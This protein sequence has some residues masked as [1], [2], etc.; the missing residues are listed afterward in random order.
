MKK[1][2]AYKRIMILSITA[3]IIFILQFTLS[4]VQT[5]ILLYLTTFSMLLFLP[6]WLKDKEMRKSSKFIL[7]FI[8]ILIMLS[9]IIPHYGSTTTT[10]YILRHW[11][12]VN[13]IAVCLELLHSAIK[14]ILN[15][16]KKKKQRT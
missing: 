11:V 13:L 4:F 10:H 14:R 12:I 6:D 1:D 3:L 8:S 15:K 7:Y 2:K 9:F 5:F 16:F